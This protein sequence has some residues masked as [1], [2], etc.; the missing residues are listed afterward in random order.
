[1]A[2]LDGIG[3]VIWYSVLEVLSAEGGVEGRCR[4]SVGAAGEIATLGGAVL[5][6]S[7][8]GVMVMNCRARSMG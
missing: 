4:R 8:K 3:A 5:G 7:D 2:A 1:M 6:D